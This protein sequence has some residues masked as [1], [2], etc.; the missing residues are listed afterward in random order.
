[1]RRQQKR[2]G[3][4]GSTGRKLRRRRPAVARYFRAFL[5]VSASCV[6]LVIISMGIAKIVRPYLI[7]Y[8]QSKETAEIERQID[9]TKKE[10]KALKRD[11]KYLNRPEGKEVEARKLG[12]VKEGE[13]ALVVGKPHKSESEDQAASSA[14]SFWR[15][16]A[17]MFV[18]K[19][20]SR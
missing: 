9:E 20:P 12:W 16:I 7:S 1:M 6:I 8:G 2:T 14:G 15:R 4:Y 5:V 19:K 3:H 10:N 13:V 17:N 11:L 18:R